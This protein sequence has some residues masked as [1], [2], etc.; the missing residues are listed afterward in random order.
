MAAAPD[1]AAV[2]AAPLGALT[3]SMT[4][5]VIP[6]GQTVNAVLAAPLGSLTGT[7]AAV[8]QHPAVLVAALGTLSATMTATATSG[9]DLPSGTSYEIQGRRLIRIDT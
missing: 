6:P 9:P 2:L 1:R 8:V 4:A 5:T 7:A 3:A